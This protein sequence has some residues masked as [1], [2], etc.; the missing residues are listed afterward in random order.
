M[1]DGDDEALVPNDS[2]HHDVVEAPDDEL[3]DAVA[4]LEAQNRRTALG[5]AG[6]LADPLGDFIEED[7]RRWPVRSCR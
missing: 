4:L 7:R 2:G 6:G 5:Q 1:G 3:P